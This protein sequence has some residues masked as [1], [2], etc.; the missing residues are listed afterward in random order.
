MTDTRAG[1]NTWTQ[2]SLLPPGRSKIVLTIEIDPAADT[3]HYGIE[4]RDLSTGVLLGMHVIPMRHCTAWTLDL[5][6]AIDRV[7]FAM[8]AL[9]SPF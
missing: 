1:V 7:H 9:I 5:Q 2:L 8:G 6:E 3:A 4:L